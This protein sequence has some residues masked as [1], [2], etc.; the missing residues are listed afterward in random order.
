MQEPMSLQPSTSQSVMVQKNR[1]QVISGFPKTTRRTFMSWIL[2]KIVPRQ[3]L[4]S[5]TRTSTHTITMGT[6]TRATLTTIINTSGTQ[7]R[8]F[9]IFGL[10]QLH[11][12]QRQKWNPRPGSYRDRKFQALTQKDVIA[13]FQ[14]LFIV[15]RFALGFQIPREKCHPNVFKWKFC[16]AEPWILSYTIKGVHSWSPWCLWMQYTV[17]DHK[18]VCIWFDYEICD[19]CVFWSTY[20]L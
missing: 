10:H 6:R 14:H 17:F 2:I 16:T 20:N 8:H 18:K 13:N 4:G 9:E 7:N 5:A 15:I 1:V 19:I 12:L 11:H 3:G